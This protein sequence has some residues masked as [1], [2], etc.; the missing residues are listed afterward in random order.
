MVFD[1]ERKAI[2]SR[3]H[4]NS[5]AIKAGVYLVIIQTRDEDQKLTSY[6]V[7]LTVPELNSG[8]SEDASD[9]AEIG[10]IGQFGLVTLRFSHALDMP[11][12]EP[13]NERAEESES[14]RR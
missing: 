13:V 2:R 8:G 7:D 11:S 5:G 14:G 4:I 12:L 10:A 3:E 9:F 6:F 1:E